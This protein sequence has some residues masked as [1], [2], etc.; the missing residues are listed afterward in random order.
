[1]ALPNFGTDVN[2]KSGV[3]FNSGTFVQSATTLSINTAA[4]SF[5]HLHADF[6]NVGVPF[7]A[8]PGAVISASGFLS[9]TAGSFVELAEQG[10][11]TFKNSS[12]QQVGADPFIMIAAFAYNSSLQLSSFVAGTGKMTLNAPNSQ[13][14][15]SMTGSDLFS[16]LTLTAGMGFSVDS[17]LTLVADPGS[18]IELGP[19]GPSSG[20][21]NIGVF[22][23]GAVPEPASA[24]ELGL[25]LLLLG[26]AWG[27]RRRLNRKDSRWFPRSR[28]GANRLLLLAV[29]VSCLFSLSTR[30]AKAGTITVDD[31]NQPI[32]V[33]ATGFSTTSISYGSALQQATFNGDYFSQ[34]PF[35]AGQS[36][37][38]TVVFQE[39]RMNGSG[40]V[41]TASTE[42]TI[43]GLANP[44]ST[45]NTSVEMFF[46]GLLNSPVPPGPG[47]FFVIPPGGFFDIAAYLR[48]QQGTD[49]PSD[50]SV[51]IATVAVPE[52]SSLTLAGVAVLMTLGLAWRVRTGAR[53]AHGDVGE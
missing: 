26:G 50:L 4:V 36:V 3:S 28:H 30:P 9:H 31:I 10:T 11:I 6:T 47:V 18:L 5:S 7:L 29:L 38:Y 46:E 42:L 33:S 41:D 34:N 44:T 22:T 27:W 2:Q 32:S 16:N 20:L 25:G 51:L 45:Q 1:V 19:L 52:P 13:G 17:S 35:L 14:T 12:G 37:T 15:F 39:P 48:G 21:P 23:G 49:V 43:T 24:V 53:S 40:L 8:S